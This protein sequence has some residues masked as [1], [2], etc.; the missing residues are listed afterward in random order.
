M[1]IQIRDRAPFEI[2]SPGDVATYLRSEGWNEV[3]SQPDR[4]SVWEREVD[5]ERAEVLLPLRRSLGDY[6]LRMA[7]IVETIAKQKKRSQLEILSDLQTA[8]IDVVRVRYR[9]SV[10]TDGSIPLDQGEALIENAREMFLAAACAAVQP[11]AYYASNKSEEA[12]QFTRGLRMGQTER[13]S[14]VLTVYS[15]VS[16]QL[17]GSQG[18]LFGDPDPDPPFERKAVTR[19]ADALTALRSATD[20]SLT[21]PNE[22]V[23]KKAIISGVSANLCAAIVG[24]S[25]KETQPSD[26]LSISFAF[27]RS[28]P[29]DKSIPREV[30]IPGDRIPIIEEAVRVYRRVAPPEPIELRG[31]VVRL[32]CSEHTGPVSGNVTVLAFAEGRPRRVQVFLDEAEHQ[33]AVDAYKNRNEVTCVGD[34]AKQGNGWVLR[35]PKGFTLVAEE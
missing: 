33:I 6:V 27:A 12:K 5:G 32:E 18:V 24:M 11:K 14:F 30:V 2:L 17:S 25:G 21:A 28:R 4:V 13:G 35:N 7:Q 19:L 31:A 8:S 20:E 22:E 1:N 9:H 10:S 15:R 26:D 23:F 29:A 3:E 16:P 34:L